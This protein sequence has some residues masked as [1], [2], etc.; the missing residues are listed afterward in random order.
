MVEIRCTCRLGHAEH[1]GA[2]RGVGGLILLR[3]G[4]AAAGNFVTVFERELDS[5]LVGEPTG[6]GPNQYGDAR[7]VTLPHHPELVVRL[8]TR[9]HEYDPERPDRLTHERGRGRAEGDPR[10]PGQGQQPDA[11]GVGCDRERAVAREHAEV[12]Q[13]GEV[14][15]D[16]TQKVNSLKKIQEG[17][18]G[19]ICFLSNPKY[20]EYAYKTKA[21]G[22][23]VGKDFEP[24][25]K[26]NTT[27][28]KVEDPYLSFTVLLEEYHRFVSFQ[29]TGIEEPS[30]IGED[31]QVGENA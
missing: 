19:S 5:I 2:V 7:D 25:K 30:Y 8:S 28:I 4:V 24:K 3:D 26:L 9:Y 14:V 21:S 22:L 23:I 18:P 16:G 29:K 20:E 17:I 27:L 12:G 13:Q 31:C 6:G 10:D 1:L 11:H 15:G